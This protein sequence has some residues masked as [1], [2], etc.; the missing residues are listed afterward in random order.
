VLAYWTWAWFAP[1]AEPRAPAAAL[2]DVRS[3]ALTQDAYGLFG[4][5][6]RDA[7]G[8]ATAP[9]SI[10]LLGIVAASGNRLGYAVLRLDGRQT[11]AVPQGAEVE[12]GLR[13]VE[14]QVDHIVL[15]RNG[16]REPLAWPQKA[17]K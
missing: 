10:K 5:G 7:G 15:E 1:R 8:A 2:A 12:P 17:A 16:G 9:G 13:L 4:G 3:A 14:V 11:L 6:R